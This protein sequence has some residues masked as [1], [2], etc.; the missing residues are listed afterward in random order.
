MSYI[1][2]VDDEP[3]F[4]TLYSETLSGSGYEVRSASDGQ[5]A[6]AVAAEE[7]PGLVISDIRMPGMDGISLLK[8]MKESFPDLPFLLVTAY[9]DIKDAVKALKLGAVDYLEKPVDFEELL[10]AVSDLLGNPEDSSV[11]CDS[12]E[13]SFPG[14]ISESF[15]MKSLLRDAA[16]VATSSVSVL[17]TG[18]SGSG[19]E[20]LAS[21]IHKQSSRASMPF[22]PV[23]CAA[24]PAPLFAGELFGYVKGAFTGASGAHDGLFRAASGGTLF[25]DEIGELP[26]ELQPALLRALDSGKIT[27]LGSGR[28][29]SVDFRLVAA[30]NRDLGE[31][32]RKG[33]FREDLFYRL[34]VIAFDIPPLRFRK[35]D[36]IP[37]A[38]FF[39]AKTAG[40]RSKRLSP[41]AERTLLAHSWPGNVRELSNAIARAVILSNTEIIL[42]E[43][44]PGSLKSSMLSQD[45][46]SSAQVR[47]IED[48]ELETIQAALKS[49]GGNRT[50]AAAVLGI[51]RRALIYKLKRYG[52]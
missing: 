3:R 29:L 6:L 25:L 8:N 39:I 48:A 2:V 33:R 42:P 34:N 43:H 44:L 40:G 7:T 32:I 51:S 50:K 1:L 36:I 18:E 13:I 19:K 5:T 30:T 12:E 35:D 4:R 16:R 52:I 41:A 9:P 45:I 23:N 28:E 22:V 15:A 38:E 10:C 31:E 21:F 37:L 49:T 17:I 14:I 47:S 24:I 20:V 26:L 46:P 11:Q 27:P